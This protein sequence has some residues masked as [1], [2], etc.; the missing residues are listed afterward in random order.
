MDYWLKAECHNLIKEIF[1]SNRTAYIWLENEFGKGFHFSTCGPILLRRAHEELIKKL[2]RGQMEYA[3]REIV[4]Q[5]FHNGKRYRK[6][7]HGRKGQQ[8]GKRKSY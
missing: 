2:Q 5:K 8:S 3:A 1:K 4:V 6:F 7:T